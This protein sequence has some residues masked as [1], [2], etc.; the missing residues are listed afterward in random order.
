MWLVRH[1]LSFTTQ[2]SRQSPSLFVLFFLSLP[3]PFLLLSLSPCAYRAPARLCATDSVYHRTLALLSLFLSSLASPKC[4]SFLSPPLSPTHMYLLSLFVTYL[5]SFSVTIV[6][7][8]SFRSFVPRLFLRPSHSP[9]SHTH[10][11]PL[12]HPLPP[13][14]SSS[15]FIRLSFFSFSIFVFFYGTIPISLL[16]KDSR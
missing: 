12:F 3:S 5:P 13:H 6:S 8:P 7:P 14:L 1:C 15:F 10:C 9:T 2:R 4:T 11:S 16:A